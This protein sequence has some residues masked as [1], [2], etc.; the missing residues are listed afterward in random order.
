MPLELAP[1]PEEAACGAALFAL[2]CT[3]VF[4]SVSEARYQAG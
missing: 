1:H 2:A 3:G 4:R